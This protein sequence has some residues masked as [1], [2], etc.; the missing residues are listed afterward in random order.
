VGGTRVIY[1]GDLFDVLP[2]LEANSVDA[3]VT[4]PPYGIGFMGK[5][6]DGKSIEALHREQESNLMKRGGR[7]DGRTGGSIGSPAA[8]AGTYDTSLDARRAF[9]WW[10]EAW[11][12][13]VLRVLRPGGHLIAFGGTRTF[14]RLTCGL[15]DAGFEIRDCLSW[16]YGSGFPKSLDVSKAIDKHGGQSVAW[17]GPW[18]RKERERRGITQKELAQHFPSKTGGLTGCVANWELGFNMP[19]PEQ[20]NTL[21]D[22]LSLSFARIEEAEREVIGRNDRPAGW[23][24][25]GDGHDVTAPS[26]DPAKQWA[27]WGTALKPSWEIAILAKKPHDLP[28]LCAILAR[29]IH[30]A[31]CQLPSSAK[32]ASASSS[33]SRSGSVEAVDSALWRAVAACNTPDA[34]FDL[35]ATSP[36]AWATSSSLNIAWSWLSTLADLSTHASTFTT[37]T[38][39]DLTTDLRILKS[40]SS[41]ITPDTIT[42]AAIWRPGI[43]SSV[44]PV[45][46]L[47]SVVAAKL[48]LTRATSVVEP[49]TSSGDGL[50]LHPDIQLATLAR[51]PLVGTVAANVL[52]HGTGAINVDACRIGTDV[53]VNPPAWSTPGGNSQRPLGGDGRDVANALRYAEQSRQREPT[54]AIGRWPAN[55]LLDE[56]AAEM[57]DAMSGET[58]SVAAARGGTSPNP[59]SWGTGRADGDRIAGYSDSGGASRFFYVAKPSRAER[60]K[61]CYGLAPKSGGE[62]TDRVDGSAGIESPRAGAGRTGGGRNGHPT[63]KPVELMRYL[64]RLVTPKDGV[65]LDPFTGSGTTGMACAFEGVRFVGI[66][67][68]AEYVAIAERR[69][70]DCLP[71]FGEP[72]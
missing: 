20:F 46:H 64:V 10:T 39:A 42:E 49:A 31:V 63:V 40:Y 45:A 6:W 26:S 54:T 70:A 60:D 33:S 59:M 66:E 61:G 25:S 52:A 36:S 16:L 37:E 35:M 8:A 22:V 53:L 15:E 43:A 69:I 72:A 67:R 48:L 27:G 3:V 30:R 12:R 14:H 29:T 21:C 9:E 41:K 65:V 18:L 58:E 4:D 55:V 32:D 71:L 23:F 38:V 11:A 24:T 1:H 34:L 51:K 5:A 50:A 44:S 13:E 19:T 57:L 7:V 47:F 68:E 2:T 62:A 28:A 56:D 17:F